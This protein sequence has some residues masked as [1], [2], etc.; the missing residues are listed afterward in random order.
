MNALLPINITVTPLGVAQLDI[1]ELPDSSIAMQHDVETVFPLQGSLAG[2]TH[3]HLQGVGLDNVNIGVFI[4]NNE[5]TIVKRN[6]THMICLT[7]SAANGNDDGG[8]KN[9]EI[10]DST[11]SKNLQNIG[12]KTS[13]QFQYLPSKTPVIKSFHPTWIS[14]PDTELTIVMK[15]INI[16]DADVSTVTVTIGKTLCPVHSTNS[17]SNSSI[18]RCIVQSQSVASYDV[19][20]YIKNMGMS[21]FETSV[22]QIRMQR[23]IGSL[24][25][26]GG[27]IYGGNTLRILGHGFF[28]SQNH[29]TIGGRPCIVV[30]AMY[31]E[32][33]CT[34]PESDG[35]A[36]KTTDVVVTSN[37]LSFSP[38]LAYTYSGRLT[39]V[40]ISIS[41]THGVGGNLLTLHGQF[42][43]SDSSEYCVQL[44]LV[45]CVV[46]NVTATEIKCRLNNSDAGH[47]NA[48]V[49]V[50][51]H[52]F[53]NTDVGFVYDLI[54]SA[55]SSKMES[56]FGGGVLLIYGG[57]G[58]GARTHVEICGK[59]CV[60]YRQVSENSLRCRSP[61]YENFTSAGATVECP[62][63]VIQGSER[64]F[65]E[66][67]YVYRR[68][69]TAEIWDVRPR[70][71]GTG[72]GVLLTIFGTN[73]FSSNNTSDVKVTINDVK[74]AVISTDISRV[75]CVTGLSH[76]TKR[77]VDVKLEFKDSGM[78]IATNGTTVDYVDLWS[79]PHTWGGGPLP[80]KGL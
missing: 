34:V 12:E 48:S 43:K 29:V 4:G 9:I 2:G 77:N 79:S 22:K 74:C 66:Q 27:S 19:S 7:P 23:Y 39:P 18:L 72:G 13:F 30:S 6:Y 3:L 16:T 53:S 73:F 14:R 33:R 37:S 17:N 46:L 45:R 64:K 8:F 32:I 31:T 1:A 10:L 40:I 5:C 52:G 56:G 80:G 26:E 57:R 41:P 76:T 55:V 67:T 65:I 24:L 58:F 20:V 47:R 35:H 11:Y 51:G 49:F 15:N 28:L 75:T 59:A 61:L 69:L 60:D 54:V 62:V 78:A 68:N 21:S 50:E 71:F 36:N 38:T 25:P 63:E 44:G 42:P 70:R